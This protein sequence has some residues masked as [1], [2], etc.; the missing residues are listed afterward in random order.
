MPCYHPLRGFKDPFY[1]Y[2]SGADMYRI[3]GCRTEYYDFKR[4]DGTYEENRF[5][6][7]VRVRRFSE[8]RCG[9]CIGCQLDHAKEWAG[10][11]IAEA[12][13]STS[14]YF[15]TFTYDDDHLYKVPV[16]VDEETGEVL[17]ELPSVSVRDWQLF[18]KRLRKSQ[19][20]YFGNDNIRYFVG[21]EYGS[22]T[23]RPHYHA[24]LFNLIL[25]DPL[26]SSGALKHKLNFAGDPI[27]RCDYLSYLWKN[28][29][30][31][32][33]P[34]NEKTAGYV[35]RYTLKKIFRNPLSLQRRCSIYKRYLRDEVIPSLSEEQLDDILVN[36]LERSPKFLSTF[37][38]LLKHNARKFYNKPDLWEASQMSVIL[39]L[40]F[41]K[42][43]KIYE[44]NEL[45]LY[46]RKEEFSDKNIYG[47]Y[48]LLEP[49]FQRSS[50]APGLGH[51]F[52]MKHMS[53]ILDSGEIWINHVKYPIPRY[54]NKLAQVH[55]PDEYAVYQAKR[56]AYAQAKQDL[57]FAK[58]PNLDRV[59][60]LKSLEAAHENSVKILRERSN[61]N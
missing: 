49:E 27:F 18:M 56:E 19:S 47:K 17:E 38:S 30:I 7:E 26:G 6:D 46:R 59:D 55:M 36:T 52:Y 50:T 2:E 9:Y 31:T 43:L 29:F 58:H 24:I 53:E 34:V 14:A 54:F 35:V 22:K 15:V 12:A 44:F 57:W 42:K 1:K 16:N 37:Y 39:S 48:A 8:F 13:T 23:F 5:S 3:A 51:K 11:I 45:E 60:H 28:G 41:D 25:P 10:R 32:I 21:A 4:S 33:A 61:I 20:K 40:P